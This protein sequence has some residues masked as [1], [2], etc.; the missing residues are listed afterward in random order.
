MLDPVIWWL[1][2]SSNFLSYDADRMYA[3]SRRQRHSYIRVPVKEL[4]GPS[5]VLIEGFA[6]WY[7]KSRTSRLAPV[8]NV[9]AVRN[10][11]TNFAGSFERDTITDIG[12]ELRNGVYFVSVSQET[13]LLKG[14]RTDWSN[15]S[16]FATRRS[17]RAMRRLKSNRSA[18]S[19]LPILWTF[20]SLYGDTALTKRYNKLRAT[21]LRPA[22]AVVVYDIR[23]SRPELIPR[24]KN[25]DWQEKNTSY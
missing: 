1:N 24:W 17:N 12:D 22:H 3:V 2:D 13:E 19:T 8:P 16:R 20:S 6:R 18:Y 15:T 14:H 5:N 9:I 25:G 10:L 4:P 23:F 11:Q 21:I 7:C